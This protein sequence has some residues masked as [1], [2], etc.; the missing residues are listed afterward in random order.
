MPQSAFLLRFVLAIALIANAL[1]SAAGMAMALGL[2]PCAHGPMLAAHD[3]G[4]AQAQGGHHCHDKVKPDKAPVPPCCADGKCQCGAIG[5][6]AVL[7]AT[8][9][10]LPQVHPALAPA[11]EPV[12][13]AP[14]LPAELLRP[15]IA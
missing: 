11:S 6:A 5:T 8:L 10:V 4:G 14:P 15:P 13:L 2:A 3:D 7:V 12:A 9:P 1:P